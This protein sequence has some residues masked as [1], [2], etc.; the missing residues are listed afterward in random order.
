MLVA[1]L[2][3][4][5]M[6]AGVLRAAPIAAPAPVIGSN[7]ALNVT[8]N[9]STPVLGVSAY[10]GSGMG[11]AVAFGTISETSVLGVL[12]ENA[13]LAGATWVVT[14]VSTPSRFAY[15]YAA[16]VPVHGLLGLP[17]GTA[18]VTA[19]FSIPTAKNLNATYS[20]SVAAWPWL[21][22]GGNLTA[23]IDLV[24]TVASAEHLEQNSS[25]STVYSMVNATGNA[26]AF[27]AVPATA[28]MT[29]PTGLLET[30]PVVGVV[31]SLAASLGV[32][33]V[34]VGSAANDSRSV[35]YSGTVTGVS[36]ERGIG[37]PPPPPVSVGPVRIPIYEF[38]AIGG[39]AGV[40]SIALAGVTRRL[41][42]TPS[43]LEY[44]DPPEAVGVLP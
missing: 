27:A 40:V 19:G 3:A 39:V 2:V 20:L 28:N 13:S 42:R 6:P 32:I 15:E 9:G 35:N 5:L 12:A 43:D 30:I 31:V 11:M 16:S 41:R 1:A 38:V 44:V 37:P 7:G 10:G 18:Q 21:L 29:G 36:P 14:N 26:S 4:L 8:M 23:E 17:V 33:E 34:T 24:P 22:A 25:G